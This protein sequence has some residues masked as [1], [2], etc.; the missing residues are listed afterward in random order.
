MSLG[1]NF[2]LFC[3]TLGQSSHFNE[4]MR[5]CHSP[6]LELGEKRRLSPRAPPRS[7]LI[8]RTPV[9]LF[10]TL[11]APPRFCSVPLTT[12][13]RPLLCSLLNTLYHCLVILFPSLYFL[14][15]A[16]VPSSPSSCQ[17]LHPSSTVSNFLTLLFRPL[18]PSVP[19]TLLSGLSL[20]PLIIA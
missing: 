15:S 8:H 20:V 9:S 6:R 13:L 16:S 19:R 3:R 12:Y 5:Q 18:F 2:F 17:S 11:S 10:S 4:L 1:S 7:V 14:R